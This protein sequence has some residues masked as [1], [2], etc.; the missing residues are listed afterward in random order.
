MTTQR[1]VLSSIVYMLISC[2]L[3]LSLCTG[4][5]KTQP[6]KVLLISIDGLRSD[7]IE[8]TDYGKYLLQNSAY[9]LE[10]ITVNPSITLPCHM[11][12][13]YS[14]TPNEHEVTT[15]TYTPTKS[16]G[17]GIT[18]TLTSQ[19]KTSAIF[20]NWK[21]IGHL[22]TENST[23]TTKYI[24]GETEGWVQANENIAQACKEH[25][26]TTPTDFTFLYLG[27]LDEHGHQ[28]GWLSEEYYNAL[29]SSFTLIDGIITEAITQ[30]YTIIITSDHGGHNYSHGST[31]I[32]DMTIPLFILG[33][34]FKHTNLGAQSILN[35]AP[36]IANILK[37]QAP[38]YWQG[39]IIQ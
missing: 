12:M 36:T 29:N 10:V 18:E 3:L 14:V 7:A 15:N 16:L 2:I 27:S 8:N 17:F 35:I 4:C 38:T 33:P 37:V 6:P 32:E 30:E 13:F 26:L 21:E 20:Y 11:S 31:A 25:L 39:T 23:T 1:S 28:F 24:A 19:N 22:I 34:D 9:S 5:T